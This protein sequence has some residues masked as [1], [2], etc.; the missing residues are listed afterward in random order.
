M[1]QFTL[2]P[3]RCV[4]VVVGVTKIANHPNLSSAAFFPAPGSGEAIALRGGQMK[5][6]ESGLIIGLEICDEL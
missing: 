3:W 2:R 4:S 1:K 6:R 5:L